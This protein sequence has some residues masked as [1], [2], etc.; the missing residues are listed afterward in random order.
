MQLP[1]VLLHS[2]PILCFP[3]VISGKALKNEKDLWEYMGSCKKEG[4][5]SHGVLAGV[6]F[7]GWGTP[8]VRQGGSSLDE[9][10]VME[11]LRSDGVSGSKRCQR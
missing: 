8:R 3:I 2:S 6:Q 5:W 1:C 7:G 11:W 10:K 4:S 9:Q